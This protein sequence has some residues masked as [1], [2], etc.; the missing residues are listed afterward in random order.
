MFCFAES[1]LD[2]AVTVYQPPE[3]AV[4][5]H[6]YHDTEH[7]KVAS[8]VSV[9][10]R[11]QRHDT[12]PRHVIYDQQPHSPSYGPPF[13]SVRLSDIGTP[14]GT[15]DDPNQSDMARSFHE[16]SSASYGGQFEPINFSELASR[17]H[18]T[19]DRPSYRS[20]G[21]SAV[22][23]SYGQGFASVNVTDLMDTP[24][25][26]TEDHGINGAVKQEDRKDHSRDEYYTPAEQSMGMRRG[27]PTS[28]DKPLVQP[29][30]KFG[31]GQSPYIP[32][33]CGPNMLAD[34]NRTSRSFRKSS[35]NQTT[36]RETIECFKTATDD[37]YS[38]MT[39]AENVRRVPSPEY[40]HNNDGKQTNISL[41]FSESETG[42]DATQD[43]LAG[44]YPGPE[45]HYQRPVK[46]HRVR[47]TVEISDA[48]D[49][50]DINGKAVDAHPTIPTVVR[51]Q[52]AHDSSYQHSSMVQEAP[53]EKATLRDTTQ[54]NQGGPILNMAKAEPTTVSP[55]TQGVFS[56]AVPVSFPSQ[57]VA[58]MSTAGP[59]SSHPD[60]RSHHGQRESLGN[61]RAASTPVQ[62]TAPV[63]AFFHDSK[64]D[65][66]LYDITLILYILITCI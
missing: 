47:R 60:R 27:N 64:S 59:T 31:I 65:C 2:T 28:N 18:E 20:S 62:P 54:A 49:L 4:A 34:Q 25:Q 53:R 22:T 38:A 56:Q 16:R 33:L 45:S 35:T 6:H 21:Q 13:R 55:V 7:R 61:P 37:R 44:T 42:D 15:K 14:S 30:M 12:S 32:V 24:E 50:S 29:P 40:R 26:H 51:H 10:P 58:S 23:N 57:F 48:S 41:V 52:H 36:D 11:P 66:Y 43:V 17:H 46:R 39:T 19:P 9:H 8:P 1:G 3:Q 5:G 63:T